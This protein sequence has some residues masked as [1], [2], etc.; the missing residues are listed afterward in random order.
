MKI[1]GVPRKTLGGKIHPRKIFLTPLTMWFLLVPKRACLKK[2]S[3]V[4]IMDNRVMELSVLTTISTPILWRVKTTVLASFLRLIRRVQG[5]SRCQ[6]RYPIIK[7]IMRQTVWECPIWCPVL[8]LQLTCIPTTSCLRF[9]V[10]KTQ[11][12]KTSQ[13]CNWIWTTS[14]PKASP[15]NLK[16]SQVLTSSTKWQ[17]V[18]SAR[19]AWKGPK[20]C[21]T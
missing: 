19:I 11:S 9:Q 7:I 4:K 21:Q 10:S 16:Y 17:T 12:R 8:H 15:I 13:T 18:Y 1:W 14:I 3:T 2:T 5:T 20:P 6:K